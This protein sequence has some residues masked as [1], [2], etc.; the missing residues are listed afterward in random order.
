MDLGEENLE[1]IS[2]VFPAYNDAPT[3]GRLVEETH[4]LLKATGR[5]FEIVVV[6]D[7]SKDGTAAVLDQARSRYGESLRVIR[8]PTNRGYGAALR[9]GFEAATKDLVFY[10]DGD[11]QYDPAEFPL[12]L[13]RLTPSIGLVNGYKLKRHDPLYRIVIGKTYNVFVRRVFGLSVRDVDCDFRL[14][15]RPLLMAAKLESDSGVICV[16]MIYALQRLGC[17]MA[18]VPVHHYPRPAGRSQ[19]F[20]FRAVV[21]TLVQLVH[22]FFRKGVPGRALAKEIPGT[23]TE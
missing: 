18:E 10:T 2:A 20:R 16:E 11:G 14:I 4:A 19:F 15:R 13:A 9:S 8:H 7:G 5:D 12:L 6:D 22:L 3:I 17:R 23:T 1:S 21:E